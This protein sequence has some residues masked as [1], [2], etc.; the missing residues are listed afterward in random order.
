MKTQDAREAGKEIRKK[1]KRGGESFLFFFP[2]GAAS[3][4]PAFPS[5]LI[6]SLFSM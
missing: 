1:G 2:A 4:V 3:L 5:E 6:F